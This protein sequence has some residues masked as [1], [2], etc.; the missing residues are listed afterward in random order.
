MANE[1]FLKVLVRD[2]EFQFPRLSETYRFNTAKK[3]SE[4]CPPTANGAA[5]TINWVMPKEK[6]MKLY[7]GVKAHYEARLAAGSVKTPFTTVFGMKQLEDGSVEFRA[8]RNGTKGDG[9][10]NTPPKVVDGMKQPLADLN[11]WGGSR[12]TVRCWAVPV[13]DP[14]GK[15]GVSLLFDAVQ[16]TEAVYGG[17]GLDDFDEH[18]DAGSNDP[19]GDDAMSNAR[20]AK[21]PADDPFGAG[22]QQPA[23]G[24]L[25]DEIPF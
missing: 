7:S 3:Q 21:A 12:G 14:E 19:F 22:N 5:W 11:I 9:T 4:P 18:P 16:V 10:T 1:D 15:G 24:G 17:G 2:V 23:A 8:K 25:D 13:T 6:A 20:G